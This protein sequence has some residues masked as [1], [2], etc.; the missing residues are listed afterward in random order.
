[1]A[2]PSFDVASIKR[3]PPDARGSTAGWTPT[4]YRALNAPLD[5]IVMNAFGVREDQLVGGPA[6]IRT[7]RF[8]IV[9]RYPSGSRPDPA[10]VS[11]MVQA[12]L[13][14]RFKLAAHK[15]RRAGATYDLVLA[16]SDR[17][18]GPRL[19]PTTIDCAAYVAAR[20]AAGEQVRSTGV[21]D[22]PLCTAVSS[23]VFIKASVRP[24][25]ALATM[26]ATQVGRPVV[27]RTGLAG[28]FEFN[29]EW[30]VD[31]SAADPSKGVVA[32]E[33]LANDRVSLFTALGE[34]LGL[35]LEPATGP[36]DVLVIDHVEPPTPD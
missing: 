17:R 24:I 27:D 26:L 23:S 34:Q 32:Q 15:E 21:G 20:Q 9:A 1:V 14:E 28:N 2:S 31:L 36:V 12:L 33:P 25:A 3:S 8:D 16:R 6:W 35:R 22:A 30:S 13:A 29:V 19:K 18:L 11:R 10:E 5:R 4:G 7:E